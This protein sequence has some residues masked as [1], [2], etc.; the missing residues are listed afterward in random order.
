MKYLF[1]LILFFSN[2][3]CASEKQALT[4]ALNAAY[5]QLELDDDVKRLEKKY[6]PEKVREYGGIVSILAKITIDKRITYTWEF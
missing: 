2:I 1:V 6:I 3:C 5:Y 4:K